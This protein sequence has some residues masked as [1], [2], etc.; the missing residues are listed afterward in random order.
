AGLRRVAFDVLATDGTGKLELTH[1][2]KNISHSPPVGNALFSIQRGEMG[3]Q[4]MPLPRARF[5]LKI[6]L[7]AP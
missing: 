1:V 5:A 6:W 2:C 7:S 4:E 3:N